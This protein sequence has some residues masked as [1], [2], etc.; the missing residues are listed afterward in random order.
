MFL[1]Q[2]S[3]HLIG[4]VLRVRCGLLAI[5]TTNMLFIQII[6]PYYQPIFWHAKVL[7]IILRKEQVDYTK[8]PYTNMGEK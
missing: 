4:V 2:M 8:R 3:K 7:K 1:H 6:R 5:S